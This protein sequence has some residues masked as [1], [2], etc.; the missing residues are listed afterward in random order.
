MKK[1]A[2]IGCGGIN[3]WFVMHLKEVLILFDKNE[4]I[5]LVTLFDE[6][7]VEEKN[8]LRKNQNF[9]I[10]NLMEN[11]AE[12]LANR[13]KFMCN[14]VFIT[15]QNLNLLDN[16]D[17]IILGVDN[18]KTRQMIYQ[19]CHKNKK[20]LLDLRAQGTQ[21]A[22]YVL[23]NKKPLEYYENKLFSSKEVME[24]K[25]SCQLTEDIENN[26]IENANK[27]IAFIGAYGIYFKHLR[28]E[29]TSTNEWKFAY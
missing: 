20:Y 2:I 25:G 15:E 19:Y 23:D 28:D 8:L 22:F 10:E 16:C 13:Y 17:D 29:E 11:K 1:I 5:S 9:E 7:F 21:M 27:I 24:R 4:D 26:H 18:N 3:S 6:D 14:K 12:I